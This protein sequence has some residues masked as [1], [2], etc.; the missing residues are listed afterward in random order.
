[1]KEKLKRILTN[2]LGLKIL[3]VVLALFTWLIMVNVS[4]PMM[5]VTHTIPVEFVNEDVLK[6]AGLTYES[7]SRNT[8]TVSYKIHVR[9]EARVSANDFTAYAD[10]AQLYD[11][12]G[13]IPVQADITSYL[14]RS[15]VQSGSV[16]VNPSVVRI[17]TE[18]I[19]TKMFMLEAHVSGTEADGYDIGEIRLTPTRVTV[20][21]AESDIG[22][23]SSLGVEINVED[24]DTDISGEAPIFFYDANGNR[25]DK[26]DGVEINVSQAAY[27]VSVLR[28][29]DL[30]LD[31][32]IT[33]TVANGYRFTGVD[34]DIRVIS[35]VGLRSVLA[36]LNTLEIPDPALNLDMATGNV[37]VQVD[38]NDYLPENISIV[39]DQPTVATV[40]MLVEKLETRSYQYDVDDV[41]LT[42]QREG[43]EY[44][45]DVPALLLQI[46]GLTE[47]LDMLDVD[48]IQV[49]ADVAE[50]EPGI[51]TLRF[52]ADLEEGFDFMSASVVNVNVRDLTAPADSEDAGAAGPVGPGRMVEPGGNGESE[53]GGGSAGTDAAAESQ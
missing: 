11:V 28:V 49:R 40:T 43:Y 10:L 34:S 21:G 38:L 24:I 47:D 51:H 48:N 2:N 36:S 4:N 12:T 27:S 18:P 37:V 41:E 29:K 13:S 46:R 9:D 20:T 50:M 39:S 14:A 52:E 53:S 19:Q 8:V 23:I 6:N 44:T 42:G 31:Y 32:K 33:G 26:A 5:T 30:T 7:L 16:T 3:S 15:L 45:F 22:Q 35:V 25:M 17:Q 1:M